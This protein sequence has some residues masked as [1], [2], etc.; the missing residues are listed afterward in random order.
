[1]TF[2]L[3]GNSIK[4]EQIKMSYTRC[5]FH[6]L[7][8]MLTKAHEASLEDARVRKEHKEHKE[9]NLLTIIEALTRAVK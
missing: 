6:L 5:D 1:L 7:F 8:A 2:I 9:H 4:T 3:P